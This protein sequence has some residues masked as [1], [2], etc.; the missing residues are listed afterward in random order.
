MTGGS[1]EISNRF[2]GVHAQAGDELVGRFAEGLGQLALEVKRRETG[3]A[4]GPIEGDAAG[5][6]GGQEIPGAQKAAECD[7]VAWEEKM[8]PWCPCVPR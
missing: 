5:E 8:A 4:R 2:G 7:V 3:L 6:A 1:P